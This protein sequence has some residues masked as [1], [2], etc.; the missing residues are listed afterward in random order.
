[1]IAGVKMPNIG[2][3][4]EFSIILESWVGGGRG[5]VIFSLF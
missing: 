2:G 1:M 4:F 5:R 3:R